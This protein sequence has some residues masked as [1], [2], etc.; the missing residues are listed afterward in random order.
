M[1]G[2]KEYPVAYGNTK[3]EAKEEAAKLA[4]EEI[5]GSK[6]AEVRINI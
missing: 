2:D 6:S 4:H 3:R 5:C 1:V